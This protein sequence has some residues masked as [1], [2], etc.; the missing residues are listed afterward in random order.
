MKRM[1]ESVKFDVGVVSQALNNTNVTGRYFSMEG[2]RRAIAKLNGGAMAAATTTKIEL[3]QAKD[4]SGTGSKAITSAEA[5]VTANTN[6]TALTLTLALVVAGTTVTING[7]TFTAHADTTT[8]A[9][10]EFSIGGDDTADAAALASLINHATY[11]VPGVTATAAAGV[12]TLTST[13]PGETVIT[14]SAS[15]GTVTVA[16]TQALAYVEIAA[17]RLDQANGFTHVAP[18]VTTTANSVVGVTM[19]R[20]LSFNPTQKAGASA[21]L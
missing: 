21:V 14:A 15:A 1:R 7:V 13:D 20:D 10:R 3:L 19:E 11:G 2:V 9:N 17:E 12:I 16:T 5:T 4:A 8:A 6:V 18:K